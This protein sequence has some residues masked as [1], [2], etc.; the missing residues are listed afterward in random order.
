MWLN[1]NMSKTPQPK[2]VPI[3]RALVV[4][5]NYKRTNYELKGC[6]NDAIAFKDMLINTYG[7]NDV[8]LITDSEQ[9]VTKQVLLDAIKVLV[10]KIKPKDRIAFY[11]S[12]HGQ[13]KENSQ[14]VDGLDEM[15]Q[16]SNGEFCTDDEIWNN[17]ITKVPPKTRLSMFFDCC[18]SGSMADLKYNFIFTPFTDNMFTTSIENNNDVS[19][20]ITCLSACYDRQESGDGFAV[21]QMVKGE[22]GK[23]QLMMGE[24]HGVFSYFL[25]KT[26]TECSYNIEC[27]DLLKALSKYFDENGYKSQNPQF[28][29]SIPAAFYSK[30]TI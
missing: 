10:D 17:L 21:S 8:K 13:Q 14:E 6:I 24:P 5:M 18:H 30:F 9:P 3:L 29:C 7:Y 11:F 4:G 12:G 23:F 15:L 27:S 19:G 26:L 22:N 20:D 28:S 2:R 25:M 16:C 1:K